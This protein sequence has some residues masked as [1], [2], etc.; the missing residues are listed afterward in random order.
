MSTHE[1][2]ERGRADAHAGLTLTREHWL[3]GSL[4]GRAY[5]E[6][7]TAGVIETLDAATADLRAACAGAGS[8]RAY[9][10]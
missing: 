10:R 1:A 4:D 3:D 5:V 2:A 8:I 6:G 9:A 7:F